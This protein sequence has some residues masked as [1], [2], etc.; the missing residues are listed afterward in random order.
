MLTK[1]AH[2]IRININY[3]LQNLVEVY[4]DKVVSLH[5]IPLSIISDKDM[6]FMSR[7]WG[8]L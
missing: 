6:R 3:S 2:F 7:F 8:S 5:V 1:S 4:I